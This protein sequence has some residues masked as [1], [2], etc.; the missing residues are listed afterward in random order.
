MELTLQ[1]KEQAFFKLFHSS[2]NMVIVTRA[3]DGQ[4]IDVNERLAA[5]LG[6]RREELIGQSTFDIGVWDTPEDRAK[7]LGALEREGRIADFEVNVRFRTGGISKVLIAIDRITLGNEPCILSTMIDTAERQRAEELKAS[8]ER[9]RTVVENSLQGMG[10]VQDRRFIFCNE[11]FAAMTGYS[12]EEVLSLPSSMELICPE[13]REDIGEREDNRL[14]GKTTALYHQH[15]IIRKDGTIRWAQTCASRIEYNG[16]PAVQVASMDITELREAMAALRIS[17]SRFR[18][19]AENVEDSFWIFDVEKGVPT[20]ASSSFD[21]IW[22]HPR[23]RVLNVLEPFLEHIH[24]DD[25]EK[26]LAGRDQMLRGQPINHE[27]RIVLPDGSIKYIWDRSS[28]VMDES[29][30]VRQI[31]GV[32]RDVTEWRRAEEETKQS[33]EYLNRIINSIG[34]PIF[35]KDR[36]HRYV[37]ANDSFCEAVGRP[38]EEILGKT[39]YEVL[40]QGNPDLY[41]DIEERVMTTGEENL[42]EEDIR[43]PNGNAHTMLTKRR[44]LLDMNGNLQIIAAIRDIT[45]Y[46]H[47]QAQLQQAQKMESIGMLAGGIAHDF[48]NLLNVINGYTDLLMEDLDPANPM[49]RD[50]KEVKSAGQRAASL[51]AQLL[52]FGRKQIIQPEILS[53]NETV[54][55]MA[56]MLPRVMGENVNVSLVCKPDLWPIHADPAQIHQIIMNLAANAR[57]AMPQGGRFTLETAN[58]DVGRAYDLNNSVAKPGLYVNLIVS[59]SGCGMDAATK[60]RLFEPFFTTK[61]R[62]QRAGLGLST[63]YGIVKQNRGFIEVYSEPGK[64]TTFKIYFPR[65]EDVG[66]LSP[67]KTAAASELRGRETI[68]VVEDETA[69]RTLLVRVLRNWGYKVIEAGDG[70]EALGMA[71]KYNDEIHLIVTDMAMPRIGGQELIKRMEKTRPGVKAI[72]I[73]GFTD[74]AIVQDGVLTSGVEFLQKPFNVESLVHRVRQVLDRKP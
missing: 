43:D 39:A 25:R 68:L 12:V 17:E 19:I 44:V 64:G 31:V 47:I 59:D 6:Y 32:G 3:T 24:P 50:L 5:F 20:Y 35:V 30:H 60:A 72:Y 56:V 14:A 53:L 13:D 67:A 29:G 8:Q 69:L 22:G 37:I 34:D 71:Q 11:A 74:Q 58:I 15:R 27:Y 9:Y 54:E 4:I 42:M 52:A 23:E 48:N 62:G 61:E 41:W 55:T 26:V 49:W 63:V 18:L 36:N 45:T 70:V 10:I 66:S 73:S 1:D 46:K 33:R 7:M 57:D 51:T 28:V 16:R 65:T 21:Q 40:R 38:R 2:S